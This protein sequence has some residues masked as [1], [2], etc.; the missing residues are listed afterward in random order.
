MLIQCQ[1]QAT[2]LCM[3]RMWYLP[4]ASP[5]LLALVCGVSEDRP[6][7]KNASTRTL[8]LHV[9]KLSYTI[10]EMFPLIT[11][12]VRS[13]IRYFKCQKLNYHLEWKLRGACTLK[14]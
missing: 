14:I 13:S 8:G 2:D 1:M 10:S 6:K 5:T 3:M 11:I 7:K 9:V 4:P 12:N